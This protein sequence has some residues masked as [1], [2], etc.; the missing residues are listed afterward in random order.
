MGKNLAQFSEPD[1]LQFSHLEVGAR[2]DFQGWKFEVSMAY[3]RSSLK[4]NENNKM[5]V[6]KQKLRYNPY[7]I[8]PRSRVLAAL[9]VR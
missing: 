7:N 3:M 6:S 4:I 9:G 2:S 1:S 8:K 5:S